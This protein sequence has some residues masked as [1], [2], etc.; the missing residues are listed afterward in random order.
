MSEWGRVGRVLKR[1]S[2][3]ESGSEWGSER[4]G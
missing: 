2:G 1:V 3:G 4:G